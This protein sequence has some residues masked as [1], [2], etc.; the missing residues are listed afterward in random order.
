MSTTIAEREVVHG[1]RTYTLADK[2]YD[3]ILRSAVAAAATAGPLAMSPIPGTDTIVV[4]GAW[5]GMIV[6]IAK[7][8][9]CDEL[10]AETAKKIALGVIAGA[11]AYW[12]GSKLFTWTLA[13]IPGIGWVTGSGINSGLNVV[14]TLWLGYALIDLFEGPNPEFDDITTIIEQ[15]TEAM[16]PQARSGKVNRI[17]G[18]FKRVGGDLGGK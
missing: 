11:G 2:D 16:K 18:F 3:T 17:V 15:L 1:Q 9:G 10:D 6:A 4:A 12:T 14:F 5:I 8:T 7:K 13:K